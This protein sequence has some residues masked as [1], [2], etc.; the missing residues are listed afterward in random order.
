MMQLLD[1]FFM[2]VLDIGATCAVAMAAAWGCVSM[3]DSIRRKL[4]GWKEEG[5]K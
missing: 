4:K 2:A 1:K 5:A 3:A